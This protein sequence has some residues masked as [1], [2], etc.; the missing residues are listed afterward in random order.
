MAPERDRRPRRP[1]P[2]ALRLRRQPPETPVRPLVARDHRRERLPVVDLHARLH[3][4]RM[5]GLRCGDLR[6]RHQARRRRE[7]QDEAALV[8]E[9]RP[10]QGDGEARALELRGVDFLVGDGR[11]EDV[12]VGW[13][14]VDVG[15]GRG[16]QCEFA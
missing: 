3:P 11:G 8:V 7:E 1:L 14:R 10:A 6:V 4:P 13:R 2:S 9:V 5:R 15:F 12:A 16:L